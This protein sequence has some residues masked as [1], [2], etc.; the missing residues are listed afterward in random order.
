MDLKCVVYCQLVLMIIGF[1]VFVVYYYKI[2]SNLKICYQVPVFKS[3]FKSYINSRTAIA[4]AIIGLLLVFY[5]SRKLNCIG[6]LSFLRL[7]EEYWRSPFYNSKNLNCIGAL[8]FFLRFVHTFS[9][10]LKSNWSSDFGHAET[11][12]GVKKARGFAAWNFL[13]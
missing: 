5:N 11:G 1:F 12:S 2:M 6:A 10:F 3:E 8:S 13:L 7:E 4:G 9:W